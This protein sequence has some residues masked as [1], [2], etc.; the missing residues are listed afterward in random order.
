MLLDTGAG[1][2]H[3]DHAK[4]LDFGIAKLLGEVELDGGDQL[5]QAGVAFGT[6]EYM[7]PEQA[8]GRPVDHRADLYAMGVMIFEML[9]GRRPFEAADKVALLRLQID[10]PAPALAAVAADAIATPLLETLVQKALQKKPELRYQTADEMLVAFDRAAL[11]YLSPVEGESGGPARAATDTAVVRHTTRAGLTE[12]G[13]PAVLRQ[14]RVVYFAAGAFLALGV[15]LLVARCGSRGPR[16]VEGQGRVHLALAQLHAA[17]GAAGQAFDEYERAVAVWPPLAGDAQLRAD[18]L[19]LAGRARDLAVRGRARE[20]ADTWGFGDRV[21]HLESFSLDLAQARTCADRRAAVP[22]LR[23][24][25][26]KRAIAALKKARSAGDS[27]KC[28]DRDARE[29]IEF[30]EALP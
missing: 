5:T 18:V 30:L 10:A 27:N 20:A 23:A 16:P 7:A 13:L 24:L 26:D 9:A 19:A 6:P 15:G 8:Q 12:H 22:R 21:D 1:S 14:R 17:S 3:H 25:K 2:D 11:D 29:A 4:L 28:L